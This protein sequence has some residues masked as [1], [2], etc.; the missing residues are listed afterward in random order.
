MDF[1]TYITF[2]KGNKLPPFY[3]GYTSVGNIFK[4]DYHGTVGSQK[5]SA[6][7]KSELR[8]NKNLFKTVILTKHKTRKEAIEKEIYFQT[9]FKVHKNPMY[10]N[11]SIHNERFYCDNHSEEAKKKMSLASKGKKKSENHK[12]NI[13]ESLKGKKKSKKHCQNISKTKQSVEWKETMG[14]YVAQ[15]SSDVQN[16]SYWK[17]T[18]GKEKIRKDLE[19]KNDPHWKATTGKLMKERELLTKSSIEWIENVG[20]NAY[21]KI[22]VTKNSSEW[23]ESKG[24]EA[25]LKLSQTQNSSEW[26]RKNFKTCPH[27]QKE[28][29]SPGNFI[30]WHGEKCKI[31]T[32]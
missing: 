27:C 14:K 4:N 7:W 16:N 1:C 11:M 19:K 13:S 32:G 20:K 8:K 18:K 5:Y 26:K 6:T 28:N 23:K 3:I 15:R 9:F 21:R 2:Y 12:L 17:A 10:I 25:A 30:R 22:S 29:I 24:K 31:I